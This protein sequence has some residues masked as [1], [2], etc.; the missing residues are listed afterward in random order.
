M[1]YSFQRYLTTKRTVDDRSL[2]RV[3]WQQLLDQMDHWQ[4]IQP[5]QP[6]HVLEIGAGTGTML[7][8]LVEWGGLKQGTYLGIDPD[9]TSVEA[10]REA[11][12]AWAAFHGF[13]CQHV[14]GGHE[15]ARHGAQLRVAFSPLDIQKF[16]QSPT[17][18]GFDLVIANAFLDLVDPAVLLPEIGKLVKPGGLGWFTIN[19]DGL[20]LLEPLIDQALDEKIIQQYHQSMDDRRVDGQW[21]GGSQTGRHLFHQLTASGWDLLAA[22]A[23]DWVIHPIQGGYQQDETYFLQHLLYF[24]EQTLNNHPGLDQ[25]AFQ[26]WLAVRRAQ[27]ASGELVFIAHQLDFLARWPL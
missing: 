21:T 23:S 7:H 12:P 13:A 24:F 26:D 17:A 2:N 8:R 1:E 9:H 25:S 4:T 20:T 15:L 27:I 5:I 22:G 18:T 16:L 3:V 10:A 14:T 19:F 11:L 6:I